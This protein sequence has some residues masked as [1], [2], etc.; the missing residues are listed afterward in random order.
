M[1]DKKR[2][3]IRNLAVYHLVTSLPLIFILIV[4]QFSIISLIT[5]LILMCVYAFIFRPLI[6]YY[7]LKSLGIMNSTNFWKIFGLIRF[8]YYHELMFKK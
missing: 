1:T 8:K 2:L 5:F 6:D 4:Y 3:T 7:R